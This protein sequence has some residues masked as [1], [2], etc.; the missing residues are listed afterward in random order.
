M[1]ALQIT[2][3]GEIENN[4]RYAEISAPAIKENQVLIE[5]RS[6]GVNPVDCKIVKGAMKRIKTLDFPAPIGFDVSG[7]VAE[8]GR[9]VKNLVLGDEIYA[10]VPSDAPG[11][12]AEF[13]AVD[14]SVVVKKPVH[15]THNEAAGI[16]LVGLTTLQALK[17]AGLKKGDT[18]LIHA[19]SGGV[20][21][22]A[23]Q[24]A[25]AL[26]ATVYTTTSTPNVEWVKKLGADRVVDYKKENYT[27]VLDEVDIVFDTLGGSHTVNSFKV[28]KKGGFMVSI[29]GPID[30]Q[31]AKEW[32]LSPFVQF[33]LRL[34][35]RKVTAMMKKRSARY[36]F[37]LMNPDA[38][39]LEEISSLIESEKI[40]PVIADVYSLPDG[41]KALQFVETGRAGGKVIIQVK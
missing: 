5:I 27:D 41:I 22:F 15:L 37:F 4:V 20:G 1:K 24:Y 40:R 2:G 10:R 25:K 16:P 13:I 19:G 11:T 18:V 3:Y 9:D 30:S 29:S 12:F 33:I 23:I 14:A 6:A 8:V 31:T 32:G 39:Q 34:S 26:G 36:R 35:S 7:T 28:L 21:T 17:M 38:A